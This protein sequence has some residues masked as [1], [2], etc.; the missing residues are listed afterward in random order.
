MHVDVD[1]NGVIL[2]WFELNADVD[3]AATVYEVL[4]ATM[5]RTTI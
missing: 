2:R 4:C 5:S 1:Q 3:A